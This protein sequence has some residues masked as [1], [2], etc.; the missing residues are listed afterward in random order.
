MGPGWV[1]TSQTV[2]FHLQGAQVVCSQVRSVLRVCGSNIVRTKGQRRMA[3]WLLWCFIRDRSQRGAGLAEVYVRG[4]SY[5]PKQV[6]SISELSQHQTPCRPPSTLSRM[7]SLFPKD[8]ECSRKDFTGTGL[9]PTC[10]LCYRQE[11]FLWIY[12]DFPEGMN[13]TR[14]EQHQF[15]CLGRRLFD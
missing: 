3:H 11:P 13:T 7:P 15:C 9:Y 6:S 8:L 2:F 4:T 10:S 12:C 1:Q 5:L 14:W